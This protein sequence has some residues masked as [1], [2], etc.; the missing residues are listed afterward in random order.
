[1]TTEELKK[2][3]ILV[4]Y[5]IPDKLPER[6]YRRMQYYTSFADDPE[7]YYQGLS[8][9]TK[10]NREKL[11]GWVKQGQLIELREPIVLPYEKDLFLDSEGKIIMASGYDPK[12]KDRQVVATPRE[13]N[14]ANI[15]LKQLD[16]NRLK[17]AT[18]TKII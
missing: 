8:V 10:Y 1:M 13:F 4:K 11:K 7:N 9:N 15:M 6:G 17:I 5:L 16:E 18:K 12:D 14:K 3:T 2:K